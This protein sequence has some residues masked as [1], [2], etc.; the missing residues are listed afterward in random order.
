MIYS[1]IEIDNIK[2]VE[3]KMNE[4]EKSCLKIN[5]KNN[6]NKE[7]GL[8][9]SNHGN[10]SNES[11]Y[12]TRDSYSSI[13]NDVKVNKILNQIKINLKEEK[14]KHKD[15]DIYSDTNSIIVN[16]LLIQKLILSSWHGRADRVKNLTLAE[17]KA[18]FK[19]EAL[20]KNLL[21]C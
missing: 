12:N 18:E 19:F 15:L 3:N 13:N 6:L 5:Q 14:V 20:I 9:Q 8:L 4:F 7:K 17:A 21:F 2:N 10:I 11:F 16:N 1:N